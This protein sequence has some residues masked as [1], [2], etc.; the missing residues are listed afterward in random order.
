M[1][2]RFCRWAWLL[3]AIGVLV[4]GCRAPHRQTV[5]SGSPNAVEG[6]SSDP[7]S[8][9]IAEAH[10]HFAMAV[11]HELNDESSEA[12]TE[13]YEAAAKDPGND[14]LVMDVTRRLLRASQPEKALELLN[15]ATRRPDACSAPL[16][17]RR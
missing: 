11:I 10:A 5:A 4:A 14:Q 7:D 13:Y 17:R 16:R 15:R 9:D 2:F 6:Q 12:L 1:L 3:T 8:N